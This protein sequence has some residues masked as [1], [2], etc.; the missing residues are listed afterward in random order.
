M[1]GHEERGFVAE[2]ENSLLDL[3]ALDIV[4]LEDDVLLQNFYGVV[5]IRALPLGQNHLCMSIDELNIRPII[6][7]CLI[8]VYRST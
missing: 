3:R 6:R 5:L 7:S 1:E 2:G 8:T 4:V